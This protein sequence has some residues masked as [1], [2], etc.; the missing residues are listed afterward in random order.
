M[1]LAE[2][3]RIIGIPI[4]PILPKTAET[5]YRSFNIPGFRP[6]GVGL[7]PRASSISPRWRT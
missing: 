7:L 4:K 1:N 6:L 3:I 2:A 5:F